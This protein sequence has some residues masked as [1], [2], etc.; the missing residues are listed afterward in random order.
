GMV[1]TIF[2]ANHTLAGFNHWIDIF[3]SWSVTWSSVAHHLW[4]VGQFNSARYD[5]TIW[6]LVHEMRISLL[7]PLIVIMVRRMRWWAALMP[8][9]VASVT[10]VVLRQPDVRQSVDVLGFAAHGG[11]TAYVLTVHYLLA[12]AIGASLAHH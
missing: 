12:F 5:F 4:F 11:F 9:V 1:G 8:F 2:F 6:A 7:F 3:W 10:V